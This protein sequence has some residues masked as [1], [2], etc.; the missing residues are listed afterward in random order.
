MPMPMPMPTSANTNSA[1]PMQWKATQYCTPQL[2]LNHGVIKS[3]H[4][5]YPAG[6][7]HR[8]FPSLDL[9]TSLLR[10]V[11]RDRQHNASGT[12]LQKGA[13]GA[14]RKHDVTAPPTLHVP[15]EFGQPQACIPTTD[16]NHFVPAECELQTETETTTV[17][18]PLDSIPA[19]LHATDVKTRPPQHHNP[20]PRSDRQYIQSLKSQ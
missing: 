6:P 20:H 4:R 10:T 1:R 14:W 8:H 5:S 18:A 12:P 3:T 15:G 7:F 17:V 16:V 9:R 2:N 11:P 13:L 19:L